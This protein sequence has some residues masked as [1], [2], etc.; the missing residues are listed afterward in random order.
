VRRAAEQ[1]LLVVML[2]VA[3]GVVAPPAEC[4][5]DPAWDSRLQSAERYAD[6]RDGRISFALVDERGRVHGY[7]ADALV[8]AASLL[9]PMLLVAYLRG[10]A[11]RD[12]PLT[13]WERSLLGPMIRRSDNVAARTML[14][15]VGA[16]G[17]R[18]VAV[19]AHMRNF[20]VVLPYWGHSETTARDQARFFY[21]IRSLLPFRHRAYALGLLSSIVESQSWGFGRI[22]HPGWRLYFKGGWSEGTGRVDHQVGLLTSRGARVALAV[23]TRFNPSHAYGK[24]TLRELAERLVGR[25]S[26]PL[27]DPRPG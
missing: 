14:G 12:R 18:R 15:L 8:H 27:G 4:I 13:D 7:R 26:V 25:L 24:R 19:R 1:A 20:R 16:D 23:T 9:K 6:R 11:V 21:R 5:V 22:E 3:M 2:A 10:P 17:L